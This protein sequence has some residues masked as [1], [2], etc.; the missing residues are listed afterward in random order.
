MASVTTDNGPDIV[1]AVS[2]TKVPHIACFDHTLQIGVELIYKDDAVDP[3]LAKAR[4]IQSIFAIS[5]KARR[6]FR[7]IQQVLRYILKHQI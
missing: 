4:K 7:E 2:L 5:T 1:L 3:V 6:I